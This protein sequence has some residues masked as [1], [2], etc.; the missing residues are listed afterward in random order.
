MEDISDVFIT[1]YIPSIYSF[2]CTLHYLQDSIEKKSN[3]FA[4]RNGVII[5]VYNS[6]R[7]VLVLVKQFRPSA[8]LQ[9]VP[10]YDRFKEIDV[11]KYPATLGITL[12]FCA[13]LE[14]KNKPSEEIAK[15]EILEECGYDVSIE[16]LEKIGTF[17]N[18]T[19]TTGA[20]STFYYCEVTDDMRVSI[21]GGEEGENVEVIEM[22]VE[23]VRDYAMNPDYVQSPINF[24]Y[25]FY[26]FLYNKYKKTKKTVINHS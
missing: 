3:V 5:I 23:E 7:N 1:D 25:G 26:W 2:P 15:E 11:S 16:Q 9:Q 24:M 19:E 22:P 10:E 6:T 4:E 14:D 12:E 20:R 13:G 17:K 8:Y 18:L 21:G